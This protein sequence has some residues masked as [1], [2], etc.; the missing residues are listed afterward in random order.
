MSPEAGAHYQ[1]DEK[2]VRICSTSLLTFQRN[3]YSMPCEHARALARL[4][5]YPFGLVMA[6]GNAVIARHRPSF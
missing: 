1:S 5:I 6:V 4:R 3:R 2:P